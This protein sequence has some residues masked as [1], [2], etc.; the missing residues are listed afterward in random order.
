MRRA[1]YENA[2]FYAIDVEA[3]D[4]SEGD[5]IGDL[6]G[7]HARLDYLAALGVNCIWLQPFFPSPNRDAGYDV[8][9]YYSV[10]PRLGNL[11]DFVRV[12]RDAEQRGIRVIIDLVVNHTSREHLW[13][14][15]ALADPTSKFRDYYIWSD[16]P[17]A[18]LR[19]GP[20]F[21]GVQDGLWTYEEKVDAYYLHWF[22][23]HQ[24]DLNL[25][26]RQVRDEIFKVMEFWL[27]L[28]VAGFR[29]DAAPFIAHK[30]RWA[31]PTDDGLWL[32]EQMRAIVD[33]YTNEGVLLAEA[34]VDA[35]DYIAFFGDGRRVNLMFNFV[36][37][38]ELFLALARE[39]AGPLRRGLNDMPVPSAG[40]VYVNWARNHDELDLTKLSEDE[41]EEVM[42]AFAPEP[43][44]R[45]YKRGI[46]R[47]LPPMLGGDRHRLELAYTAVM[48]LPG[49]PMLRYG[50]E[51]GMGDDL[52]AG[53]RMSVRT[54]MQWSSDAVAGFTSADP[55]TFAR[56]VI[57]EGPYG[58]EEVNVAAQRIDPG[59][60]LNWMQRLIRVRR[61]QSEIGSG[62]W[63][64]L[65]TGVDGVLAIGYRLF[66]QVVIVATN[67]SPQACQVKLG[68]IT[69]LAFVSDVFADSDY[70]A[71]EGQVLAIE[72]Y[73]YR[74]LRGRSAGSGGT[75][76][77][78]A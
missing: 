38:N 10:D 58:Y 17:V 12:V 78:S 2:T 66:D 62:T 22:Y 75:S 5:G 16:E 70:P 74:W 7:V 56:P 20:V 60:F 52:S 13:F 29:V 32:I 69:E 27:Q 31:D 42:T 26:N 43:H 46:R 50:E 8:T 54:V 53:E 47:R 6:S 3:F 59:S 49:A 39:D 63:E 14:Q 11:G 21:P 15:Q 45:V 9:D 57:S 35:E 30:A 34:N 44:M 37:N 77:A 33:E 64:V 48:S 4:D 71:P 40:C 23:A 25:A 73:G 24:P 19:Y 1:W 36:W 65:D 41:R 61:Q 72:G 76:P 67:F 51:I 18:D 55:E 28:G 68:I